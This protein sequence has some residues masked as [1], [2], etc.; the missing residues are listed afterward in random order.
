[1]RA[2]PL[3]GTPTGPAL[4]PPPHGHH[5]AS[6][7][8]PAVRGKHV[9]AGGSDIRADVRAVSGLAIRAKLV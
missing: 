5:R 3:N 2:A 4:H 7:E 9:L 8:R 1:M 6:V